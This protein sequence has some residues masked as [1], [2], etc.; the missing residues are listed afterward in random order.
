MSDIKFIAPLNFSAVYPDEQMLPLIDYLH[1]MDREFLKTSAA[2]LLNL[3]QQSERYGA[4][5]KFV[6][7]FF[8]Q[9][10]AEVAN[11]ILQRIAQLDGNTTYEI[12]YE[13]STLRLFEFIS[14]TDLGE[15][16]PMT[17]EEIEIRLFKAYLSLN[18]DTIVRGL[19][20]EE[21]LLEVSTD[22]KPA[23]ALI[24]N[25]FHNHDLTNWQL[26][27]LFT[28][29]M[30]RA[31]LFFQFLESRP[32]CRVLLDR[33]YQHFKVKNYKEYMK[34]IIP[35]ATGIIFKNKETYTDIVVAENGDK[36]SS[37]EFLE[38]LIVTED[39][40][41]E[42][43]D[44]RV[45]RGRPMYKTPEENFR[46]ISP[47]FAL[48]LLYNGLYWK[49]KEVNDEL[50]E[51]KVNL[52]GLKTYEFSEKYVVYKVL[53]GIFGKRYLQLVGEGLGD[54]AP[55]YYTR[56]G[57]RV[58]LFESKDVMLPAEV[59]QSSDYRVIEKGLS[60]KLYKPQGI[61]QII[62]NVR[63]ALTNSFPFDANVPKNVIVFPILILHNRSF[64]AAGVNKLLDYWFNQELQVLK[65]EGLD[66]SR[67]QPLTVIDID[68][69]IFNEY[70]FEKGYLTFP[71]V[72]EEYVE[73]YLRYPSKPR[74]FASEDEAVA[75]LKKSYLPFSN[76]LDG[77]I[78][79][80]G[81]RKPPKQLT[82][83]G[84]SLFV[85]EENKGKV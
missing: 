37:I 45:L 11:D 42:D 49:L 32:E 25:H 2:Y 15:V 9:G 38:K 54:G 66:I 17:K 10:N 13:P 5:D 81:L 56:N 6:E 76:F 64:M 59:K 46:I 55:D 63:R 34:S 85:D 30:I 4:P 84:Y 8:S 82:E 80:M 7:N 73:N 41:V 28:A 72:I 74:K 60:D 77:K 57:K 21:S 36:A 22:I 83:R 79:S 51:G 68:T 43:V 78:D 31:I 44:F 67:V 62:N 35:I 65:D 1:G 3:N 53:R 23:A 18:E 70:A 19:I 71:N 50:K 26:D 61:M 40:T 14:S 12:P 29:Q 52:L 69:L 24:V 48:E 47:L 39:D 33:F 16:V 27:K 20:V 75:A 58:Y